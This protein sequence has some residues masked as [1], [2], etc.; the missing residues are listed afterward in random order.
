MA[1][2][3]SVASASVKYTPGTL[4]AIARWKRPLAL[5]MAISA[6]MQPAP[7]D[8]PKTVT[9]PGSPPKAA[10]LSWTQRSAATW[11]RSPRFA[12]A[13]GKFPKPSALRR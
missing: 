5:G 11:S 12:G 1:A 3:M 10:M 6:A 9:R 2:A 4:C 8:S 13:P 7:D